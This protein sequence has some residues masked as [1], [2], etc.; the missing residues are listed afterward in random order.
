M[1]RRAEVAFYR[2]YMFQGTHRYIRIVRSGRGWAPKIQPAGKPGAYYLRYTKNGRRTFES[3]GNDLQLALQEK[4]ARENGLSAPALITVLPSKK[5][6]RDTMGE[7]LADKEPKNWRHILT[8][9][10][11]WWGWEKDPAN[12][13]RSEFK[14]FA[15]HIET[16][17]LRPRTR[18]NYLSNLTTFLRGTGRVVL[19]ARNEQDATIKKA[20]AFIPNTL[21]LTHA[22][23]PVVNKGIKDFYSA[24][25]VK[26]LFAAAKNLRERLM[27][28][29]FYYTGCREDEVA[30]LFW[31]DIRWDAQE[32][33]VRE[34][35]QHDWTTKTN[36][37]RIVEIP[38]DLLSILKEAYKARTT[39]LILPNRN[40]NP[41]GHLLKKVQQIAKRAGITCGECRDCVE[42]RVRKC[43]N[44][45]LHKFRY[46][47][48]RMLDEGKTPIEDIRVALGH[49]D[50]ST[51]IGYLG[52]GDKN[53]RRANI[54]RSFP[55]KM[56]IVA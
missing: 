42:R 6:L 34:K 31:T 52:G 33:L 27:L 50:I 30:H 37:D 24:A 5:S 7:F 26:A 54:E 40:G 9:F 10:G 46:T 3:V 43:Q 19:V 12:F 28:S 38:E 2:M 32:I 22:D 53:Q 36:Q 56:G 39:K 41:D 8:T 47:Y 21:I 14:A 55:P 13:Q 25:Q 1:G 15:R 51:T 17:D 29:L 20:T 45:G 44:F 49:E 18:R 16:L 48:G 23:F 35:R 4:K 11:A